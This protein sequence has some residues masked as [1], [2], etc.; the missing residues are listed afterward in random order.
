MEDIDSEK[1]I[2]QFK[3]NKHRLD[4]LRK[5][6]P[7]INLYDK[8]LIGTEEIRQYVY[9]PRILYFRHVLHSPMKQTY[10]MEYGMKKHEKL[11]NIAAKNEEY[12][13]KYYNIYLTDVESGLVGLIDYFEFDGKEAYPVEIKSGNIPPE[14][15]DNPHKYQVT[16]QAM[17]IE[18]NFDFLV[19]K[20]K[21]LYTK[22]EKTVEYPI[23]IEDKLKVLEIIQ[24]VYNVISREKIPEPTE[25]NGKCIDCECKNYCL[26]G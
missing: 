22:E 26:Q 10:K 11:Q 15:L 3:I 8:P 16:A 24:H 2:E 12:I 19:K 4:N 5:N 9:C 18:S 1:G 21:V 23:G 14:G 20:V 25:D 13:H 6:L 7:K 17:L